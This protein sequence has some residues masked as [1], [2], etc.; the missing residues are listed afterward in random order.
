LSPESTKATSVSVSTLKNGLTIVSE[1]SSKASTVTLTYPKAG[2]A[3]E[4]L[5]EQGAALACKCLNFKSGSGL[6]SVLI[7]RTIE[8]EGGTPFSTVDRYAASVG[9]TVA[10]EKAVGLVPL[11]AT[12]CTFEKWDVRDARVTAQ[13]EETEAS[14]SAQIVLTENLFAAAYGPQSLPGRPLYTTG[15]SL[16]MIKSFRSRAYG[17][18]GAVLTATGI[19][20]HSAF[21]REAESLLSDASAGTA[22]APAPFSYLGGE[23]RVVAS[24]SGYA[25]V[26][27]AFQSPPVSVVANVV[28]HVFNLL[29]AEHGV[30][31]FSTRGLV[32][33]YSGSGSPGSL[34]DAMTITVTTT[35]SSAIIKRAKSLAKAEALFALDG[36]TKSLASAMT[37]A[38]LDGSIFSNPADVAA[39]YDTLSEAQVKNAITTIRKCKPSMAAVGDISLVPYHAEVA[40]RLS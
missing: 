9:Y 36:G 37:A 5:A 6:S 11:L 13:A 29:G 24:T 14:N 8:D 16:D 12:A 2:S 34:V 31:A 26:A 7:N 22:E 20:D 32:G 19:K 10:P 25:L 17:L 23:S 40:T 4:M 35:I 21:C 3:S 15:T 18:H 39:S 1:D 33:V 27:L 28:K 30:S 38:F